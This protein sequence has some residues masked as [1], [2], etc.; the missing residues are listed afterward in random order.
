MSVP[1][2]VKLL[3]FPSNVKYNDKYIIEEV[4]CKTD[5][6]IS[7]M[8]TT[9]TILVSGATASST[10]PATAAHPSNDIEFSRQ[11]FQYAAHAE[12]LFRRGDKFRIYFKNGK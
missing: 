7:T 11:R 6:I 4:S 3:A 8:L 5:L 9:L 12:L 2:N 10:T 1:K